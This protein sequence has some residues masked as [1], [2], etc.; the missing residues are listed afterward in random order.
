MTFDV[1]IPARCWIAP[2]MPT[3]T[4]SVG[5][6]VLPVWPTCS[7]CGRH[8]ASTT[9]R[10]APTAA[11]P[12]AF[13]RSSINRKCSA[14]FIPRPPATT[15]SASATSSLPCSAAFTSV[16]VTRAGA[17]AAGTCPTVPAF[18]AVPT[19]YVLGRSESTAGAA[20]NTTRCIAF[21]A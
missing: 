14:A 17:A 5:L 6:T 8:P 10:E 19:T 11:A 20:S 16:T 18:A 21:P 13:A 4:Y 3:A 15:M 2:E 1:R 7:A 12:N 9:A